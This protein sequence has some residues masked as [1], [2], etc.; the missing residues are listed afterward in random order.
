MLPTLR[1]FCV[2]GAYK[3]F[4]SRTMAMLFLCVEY[5]FFFFK[6]EMNME[7]RV[8]VMGII[9][10]D[11]NAVNL[12]NEI[13]HEYSEYIIGRMGIPYKQK[14]ISVISIALDAPQNTIA[15]L[16]GKLGNIQGISVKTA[17]S[18]VISHD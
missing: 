15:A 6:K 9:V 4:V 18:N 17:Y 3:K 1:E 16:A 5:G 13:L 14:H 2:K 7:T 10:E 8:A 12:L 11:T